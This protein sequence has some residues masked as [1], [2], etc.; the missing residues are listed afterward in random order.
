MSKEKID[1]VIDTLND[2]REEC[3]KKFASLEEN[4]AK[5]NRC[6]YGDRDNQMVGMMERVS[7]HEKDINSF[8][9]ITTKVVWIG[10]GVSGTVGVLWWVIEKFLL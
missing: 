3:S 5:L 6:M 9:K 4:V 7:T 1:I 2:F 10:T 8:K